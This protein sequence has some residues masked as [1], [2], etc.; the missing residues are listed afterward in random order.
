[1]SSSPE[2][3]SAGSAQKLTSTL[4]EDSSKPHQV[5]EEKQLNEPVKKALLSC[6]QVSDF[7][8]VWN[9]KGGEIKGKA[10]FYRPLPP[11]GYKV[12][13]HYVQE[14]FHQP[15]GKVI[16]V[17]VLSD[18]DKEGYLTYPLE[19]ECI[20]RDTES[21][22]AIWRPIPPPGYVSLGDVATAAY[23]KPNRREVVCLK[24]FL[25]T[26]GKRGE[27]AWENAPGGDVFSSIRIYTVQPKDPINGIGLNLF[28]GYSRSG[29]Q[30][31]G[32][33]SLQVLNKAYV[34]YGEGWK[35]EG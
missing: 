16:A 29:F 5:S 14:D 15:K 2:T 11:A 24:D 3:G 8:F 31:S 33:F 9:T 13:G 20:W 23:L 26:D 34:R 6:I 28:Q 21:N 35:G 32:Y 30:K 4:P 7:E 25:A 17:K 10:T 1:V 18:P 22:G 19:Y 12:F 27:L